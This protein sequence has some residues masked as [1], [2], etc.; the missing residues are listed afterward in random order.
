MVQLSEEHRIFG[1][2][3][4]RYQHQSTSCQCQMTFSLFLPPQAEQGPV[5]LLTWLSGLTC[6][7][8][9]F[10]TKSGCQRLAAQYGFAVLI[11]DT[12]P[13]GTQV[14]DDE[15]YDLGQGAGFY[16]DATEAPWCQHYQMS[17]Y[18][19]DELPS[20]IHSLHPCIDMARH[21]LFG[22]SM[23][24]HGALVLGIKHPHK[25]HSIS[26]FSPIVAPSQCEWG[27]KIFSAY[28]GQDKA[29]WQQND[30]CELI[31]KQGL[32]RSILVDQGDADPFLSDQLLTKKLQE[33]CDQA[34]VNCLI[35]MQPGYDH[36]YYFI[37]TF[38]ED[39]FRYHATQLATS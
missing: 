34:K 1:G 5:P 27:E 20:L 21:G 28:L 9:N 30:A 25:Y 29:V 8:E 13:R 11:P 32:E 7:D 36:S 39:H 12:S 35:R 33:A 19:T 18:I 31:K 38:L 24:G 2:R 10:S 23:G 14:P 17:S 6:T 22:H 15:D 16:I 4:I 3:Q 37:A 26:A